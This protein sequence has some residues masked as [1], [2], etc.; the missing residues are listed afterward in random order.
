MSGRW[1]SSGRNRP[2][3]KFFFSNYLTSILKNDDDYEIYF[4]HQCD[5]RSFNRG[6]TK[7]IGFLAIKSKYPEHYKDITII[8]NDID[9]IPFDKI[10]SFETD[11]GMV[12][13]YYGFTYA[14]GGI[15][16]IKGGDF[17]ATNGYPNFWG[18]GKEDNV[19]QKRCEKIGLKI[20]RSEFFP[21]GS[22]Q[23]L[24]L[25]DGINRII[26][27][28]DPWRA[29]HD[30]GID[31][32]RTIN[33]L[34]YTIDNESTNPLD[35][36]NIVDNDKIF[37]IN[38]STFMTSVRFEDENYYDYDIREPPRK[39]INPSRIRDNPSQNTTDDWSK[40]PFYPNIEKRKELEKQYGKQKANEII[41]YSYNNSTDPTKHVVPP[42]VFLNKYSPQYAKNIGVPPRA[43]KSANIGLGGIMK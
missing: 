9:T 37:M 12:K 21:I 17:E 5:P 20:D 41:E 18:W 6:A 19:L 43:S 42:N 31:G 1:Q 11:H 7:N 25:F 2:Q 36:I 16:A 13:H 39:I 35:N 23:I 33:K 27:K 24:H 15:I 10:V 22:P 29:E 40:I 3:H 26:N 28:K 14:L 30:N 4:S 34:I 38:I 8:F 32:L